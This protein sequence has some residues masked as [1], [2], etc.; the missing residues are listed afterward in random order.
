MAYD[1]DEKAAG[2][3]IAGAGVQHA[4][5]LKNGEQ[6]QLAA[7]MEI[8]K[9]VNSRLDLNHILST[10]SR[11]I[12]KVIE[13]DVGCVAVYEKDENCLYTRHIYRKNGDKTG[14]GRYV[15]LD[16]SNLIGWVAINKKPIVRDNIPADKRFTEIMKEDQLKSDMV[17]PLFA[18]D[19]FVGTVNIGS[20]ECNH[21]SEFDLELMKKFGQLTS[22]ALENSQLLNNLK[23]LGDKYRII[24]NKSTDL[25]LLLDVSGDIVECNQAVYKLSG[26][27]PEEMIGKMLIEFTL[28]ARREKSRDTFG[29]VLRGEVNRF[30]EIPY[31]KKNG[32]LMYLD[33]DAIV[34]KI[35]EHPY[36]LLVG[37]DVSERKVLQ[38][39]ITIQN[40]E[41]IDINK[42][43]R[44]LDQLKSEFLGRVSHELRTPLSIIMAYTGTLMEDRDQSI[45]PET[46]TDFL[47]VIDKQSHK[48]LGLI[49]DLLDLSKV[50]VS[51]TMLNISQGYINE[52]IRISVSMVSPSARLKQVEIIQKLDGGIPII[53]YDPLRIKQVCV[54]LL[55]NAVKFAPPGG[56]VR[57]SSTLSDQGVIVAISDNGPGIEKQDVE[58]IFDNFTQVDGGAT[59]T[60]NGMG[61]GLRLVQHYIKLHQG[62]IWV[63]S[64]TGRGSTFYFSLPLDNGQTPETAPPDSGGES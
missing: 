39:K 18:K 5:S 32:E 57:I 27:S 37:H 61:I 9:V 50:E 16:E 52:M 21:F 31:L 26:Y 56:R 44:E 19:F 59:R 24:M 36:V 42:K 2:N 48:L 35:K 8:A 38:E 25:I 15:P 10:I 1:T 55:S 47:E 41:L 30:R 53:S 64:E 63:E 14:E 29:Q 58:H 17:V 40:T 22:I 62:R 6:R 3:S 45:E 20:Y 60:S 12:S 23:D 28:P 13:F 51:G 7:V 46:R 43:L 54:N 4:P 11:E 49:N 33:A 34:I